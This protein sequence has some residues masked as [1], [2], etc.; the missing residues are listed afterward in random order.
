MNTFSDLMHGGFRAS[1]SYHRFIVVFLRIK[2]LHLKRINDPLPTH[3]TL[4]HRKRSPQLMA[5]SCVSNVYSA[6]TSIK[7]SLFLSLIR[8][9]FVV[10]RPRKRFCSCSEAVRHRKREI[11]ARCD[12][13][14]NLSVFPKTFCNHD[15][16]F[17]FPF[18]IV[19]IIF[20][21]YTLRVP[22]RV[23]ADWRFSP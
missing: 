12:E 21:L 14:P 18:L 1:P 7:F 16:H 3:G 5:S 11:F 10:H 23:T 4:Y 13:I 17:Y 15:F 2:R 22:S 9:K 8:Y 19:I 6:T 20:L